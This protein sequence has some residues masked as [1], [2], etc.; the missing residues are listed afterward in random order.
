[1]SMTRFAML[2]DG[3]NA[4]SEEYTPWATC[5]EC[6]G[7]FCPNCSSEHAEDENNLCICRSCKEELSDDPILLRSLDGTVKEW[8]R[9]DGSVRVIQTAEAQ[10]TLSPRGTTKD[11]TK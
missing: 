5:R 8:S 9:M 7:D 1:M 2:C 3:C 11:G 4:R 6:Q 10:P